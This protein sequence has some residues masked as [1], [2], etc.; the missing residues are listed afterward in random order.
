MLFIYGSGRQQINNNNKMQV[1]RW[2]FRLPC[3]N[4]GTTQ[5]ASR[6]TRASIEATGCSH[7]VSA[8]I[9]T[10]RQAAAM[11]D[12]FGQKHKTLTITIV[13]FLTYGRPKPKV[14]RIS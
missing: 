11:I 5:G 3:R 14:V 6:T 9:A 10:P 2:Q 12:N 13:S 8:R 7:R 1:N 4:G